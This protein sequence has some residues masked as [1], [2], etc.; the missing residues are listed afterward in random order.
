MENFKSFRL[1]LFVFCYASSTLSQNVNHNNH[2]NSKNLNFSI[3]Q[4]KQRCEAKVLNISEILKI[5]NNEFSRELSN[6]S[7]KLWD[8]SISD[9]NKNSLES[10]QS[11]TFLKSSCL[12]KSNFIK[13]F[14]NVIDTFAHCF[15]DDINLKEEEKKNLSRSAAN[16]ICSFLELDSLIRTTDDD[17]V[18]I[19]NNN[20][21]CF[22]SINNL[23]INRNLSDFHIFLYVKHDHTAKE[24]KM[25][26]K[27]WSCQEDVI[28]WCKN[29]SIKLYERWIKNRKIFTG[30]QD[31]NDTATDTRSA[32]LD[33][34]KGRFNFTIPEL[35]RICESKGINLRK[36]TQH[37][38][39]H[40][41]DL[42]MSCSVKKNFTNSK[43]FPDE[44]FNC[45]RK[46]CYSNY[47]LQSSFERIIDS[48][49]FCFHDA[50]RINFKAK[51][52]LAQ[53]AVQAF[54]DKMLMDINFFYLGELAFRDPA[55]TFR[56]LE[57]CY[58]KLEKPEDEVS[59]FF[60]LLSIPHVYTEKQCRYYAGLFSCAQ[61]EFSN[62][63]NET[64]AAIEIV[65]LR[66]SNCG[67]LIPTSFT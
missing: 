6:T 26:S 59:N 61:N 52:N 51:R 40:V 63:S 42:F 24:C 54:C 9:L 46:H 60:V 2:V 44:V 32:I 11:S 16:Q 12:E 67:P 1:L 38:N 23:T 22:P 43:A 21:N 39:F 10:F 35:L 30:C 41:F 37:A 25:L 4:V 64:K 20:R 14:E 3:H 48:I 29:S 34:A 33:V 27:I 45:V 36:T 50:D 62:S 65:R 55:G 47:T 31:K 13:I 28:K 8:L 66:L 19:I 17:C 15:E 49:Q 57:N 5:A 7:K 18:E 56:S 53:T 58:E